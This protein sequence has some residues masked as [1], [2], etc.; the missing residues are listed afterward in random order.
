MSYDTLDQNIYN[1][2]ITTYKMY[3]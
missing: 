2:Y 1:K 3:I